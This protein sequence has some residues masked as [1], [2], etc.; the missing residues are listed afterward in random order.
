MGVNQTI[1][2]AKFTLC[3]KFDFRHD[4]SSFNSSVMFFESGSFHAMA[5]Y[6]QEGLGGDS[7]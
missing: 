3:T 7:Q 4:R 6:L 2:T 1:R 5:M